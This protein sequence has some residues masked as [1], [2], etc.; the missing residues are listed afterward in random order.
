MENTFLNGY[1]VL[2]NLYLGYVKAVAK[3]IAHLYYY[4][5]LTLN[6]SQFLHKCFLH[7]IQWYF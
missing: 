2:M 7:N 5:V 4:E 6:S 3:C 1:I